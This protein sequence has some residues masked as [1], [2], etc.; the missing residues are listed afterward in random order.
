MIPMCLLVS[1]AGSGERSAHILVDR[2]DIEVSASARLNQ[3]ENR[4]HSLLVMFFQLSDSGLLTKVMDD[5]HDVITMMEQRHLDE[6]VLQVT[7]LVIRPA[8]HTLVSIARDKN[9][10]YLAVLAG[11]YQPQSVAAM[12]LLFPLH[13]KDERRGVIGDEGI[14]K[15][16]IKLYLSAGGM[17]VLKV[18]DR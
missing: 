11:Y 5:Y 15:S 10:H 6:T 2:V 9:A 14:V 3:F 17:Q 16:T 18:E 13:V 12:I 8:A 4:P 1:C 7:D